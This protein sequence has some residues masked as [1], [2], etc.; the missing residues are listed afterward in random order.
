MRLALLAASVGLLHP[1]AASGTAAFTT[2]LAPVRSTF[3][4][5]GTIPADGWLR[6]RN[7]RG[8]V[9]IRRAAGVTA[10]VHVAP[11]PEWRGWS[12]ARTIPVRFVAER[13]GA[14]VVICALSDQVTSCDPDVL[15]SDQSW[16][17]NTEPQAMH[18]TVL[19]PAGVS[20]QG[21]TMH[22]DVSVSGAGGD[23][24]ARTGHGNLSVH[25]VAGLL[26]ANTG[27]GDVDVANASSRVSVSSGH[28]NVSVVDAGAAVHATTGHGDVSATLGPGAATGTNDML[29]ETGHGNVDV[30]APRSLSGDID[31]HTGH[32]NVTTSFPLATDPSARRSHTEWARGKLGGGTRSVR[33]SSGHGDVSLTSG[34]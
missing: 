9:E 2:A 29:F 31:M 26:T 17:D 27:H 25:G 34:G 13:R 4:W 21:G 12:I 23:V 3:D 7:L 16:S 10:E 15:S 6:I 32:G 8:S 28:G 18:V 19:L 11:E 20:V 30:T 33:L 24:I 14:D 1:L 22:G 5:S